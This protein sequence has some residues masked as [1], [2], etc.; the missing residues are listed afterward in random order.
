[1]ELQSQT[2]TSCTTVLGAG[3][4]GT[5][6]AIVLARNGSLTYLWGRDPSHIE[7]MKKEGCNEHY[8][9][10]IPF[11]KNLQLTA[12]LDE[13]VALSQD[14]IIAV[15]SFAF[16]TILQSIAQIAHP[17]A[18]ILSATK[19]LEPNTCKLFHEVIRQLLGDERTFG[20]ISG[21]SFALE[22]AKGLPTAVTLASESSDLAENFLAKMHNDFF[23][24]YLSSD[25]IGVEVCG[26]I[27]NVIA[28]A[29]GISDGMNLGANARA[30]LITR[31]LAEM[32][33][34]GLAMGGQQ[35]T[36]AGLA[37]V[38][39]LVLTCTD[40]QSRNRRFGLALGQGYKVADALKMIGRVVEGKYNASQVCTLADLYGV[41]VPVTNQ[42]AC[43]IGGEKSP[44]Q[45]VNELMAR[46]PRAEF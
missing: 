10:G 18:R 35:V 36:F 6:L 3:A 43:I 40:D 42:V 2:S 34:L 45:V 11:P 39:D 32:M 1:M 12:N 22:V 26:A 9:P 24:V 15:P 23:R 37:G 19:G 21:P 27:K 8:L 7:Q 46:S 14:L 25:V 41:E 13:A 44:M 30:G 16:A 29:T 5:A 38:G 4:W 31:G 20:V 33:R 28:I 17:H